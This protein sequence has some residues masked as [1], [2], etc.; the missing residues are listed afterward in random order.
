MM[1]LSALAFCVFCAASSA[2]Y[3]F[4]DFMDAEADRGDPRKKLRPF[5]SGR[6]SKKLQF[7]LIASCIV[8]ACAGCFFLPVTAFI[9]LSAYWAG[10]FIYSIGLKRIWPAGIGI[11][12][13]GM[14][15]RVFAG[16]AA[17]GLEVSPWVLPCVFLL[18]FYVVAGKRIFDARLKGDAFPQGIKTAFAFCGAATFFI[19]TYY[20]RYDAT[21]LKYHTHWLIVTAAPVALGLAEYARLVLIAPARREHLEAVVLDPAIAA[22]LAAWWI[23]FLIVIY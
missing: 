17:L 4:N 11:I 1:F 5:A 8:A 2:A 20:T 21:M 3:L 16:A 19:Y 22:S 23:A 7:I 12:S 14:I 9:W 18:T 15:A 6:T 10:M 13:F